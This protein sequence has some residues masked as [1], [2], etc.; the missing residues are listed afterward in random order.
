L[1]EKDTTTARTATLRIILA[2]ASYR[3]G[4]MEEAR[5]QLAQG[6]EVIEGKFKGGLDRGNG[7]QGFWYDWVF[8]RILLREATTIIEGKGQPPAT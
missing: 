2:M 5:S 3:N 8:A 1:D 7:I 6:R 4:Q